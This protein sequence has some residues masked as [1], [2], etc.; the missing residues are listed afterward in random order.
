MPMDGIT[1]GAVVYELNELLN[2]AKIDKIHQPEND[3]IILILRK[4]ASSYKLLLSASSSHARLQITPTSKSNPPTPTNFCMLLRKHLTGGRIESIEQLGNERIVRIH[5]L[6]GNEMGD[7]TKKILVLEIMGKYSNLIFMNDA[8]TILDA[9]RHV[10]GEMSR[11]RQVLPHDVYELPPSQGK[12]EPTPENIAL[13]LNSEPNPTAQFILNNFTGI[14]K[15]AA[16]EIVFRTEQRGNAKDGFLSYMRH[17]YEHDYLPTLLTDE[18]GAPVDYLPFP[19]EMLLPQRQKACA[20]MSEAFEQYFAQRALALH[21]R[22]RSS[23]LLSLLGRLLERNEKK[24]GIYLQKLEECKDM[25]RYRIYGELLTANLYAVKRGS[26]SVAVLNYYSDGEMIDIPLDVRINPQANA[27]RYFKQ[28]SKLK[29]AAKLLDSQIRENQEERS[30]LESVL[31]AVENC[32]EPATLSEIREELIQQGYLRKKSNENTK[33]NSSGINA[34]LRFFS[35]SGTEILVGRNNRQNDMLTLKIAA[36]SDIWLHTKEIP[37]SHV[38]IRSAEPAPETLLYAAQL[39]AYHSKARNSANVPVDYTAVKNVK[40]PGGAKP[41]MV[42]YE[43]NRTLY[44]NP[45]APN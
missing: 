12:A 22:A 31:V 1:I 35:P 9:I 29:T 44:V 25:E 42:I 21:I 43:N 4:N 32:T 26:S 2:G 17:V 7:L 33:K 10:T 45:K 34:P 30:Y 15:Q 40:K 14:S 13:I 19:Y 41:G 37:G 27:Q 8:G 18:N 3:E 28:F 20:T 24:A 11:E 23:E 38:I 6:S 16:A 5:I 39:A 36:K